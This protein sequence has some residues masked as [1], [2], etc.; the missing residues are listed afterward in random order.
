ME[1]GGNNDASAE[2]WK[3]KGNDLYKKADYRGAIDM[4]TMAIELS[5][6]TAAYYANRA[7]G[8]LMLNKFQEAIG[9]SSR[10][11]AMEPTFLRGYQRKAKAQ[12]A[13]GE[14]EAAIK[15]YQ[16]GLLKD[17]N[18]AT[19]INDRRSAEIAMDK[20]NRGRDHVK[21][22][23]FREAVFCF[24]SALTICTHSNDLKKWRAEALIG[25]ERYDE[26]FAVL[27]QL[28]RSD[29]SS[30]EIFYLRAQ[31]LYYQG[32]FTSAIRHL[33]EA[34]RADPD[35]MR[36]VK[37]I[38][39]IRALDT[40]K[41]AANDAFKSGRY[42]D[43]VDAYTECLSIDPNNKSYNAKLHCNRAA[44]L[45]KLNKNEEAIKD[46]DKAI[47]YDS[48][49]VKAYLRKAQCLKDLGGKE[50]LEQAL[51]E[52]ETASKLV[53]EDQQRQYA[54][55]IRETKLQLKKAKRKDYY[56]ILDIAQS[57]SE[58]DIKKAYRKSA[59]KYHPDRHANKT[60]EEKKQAEIDFK[61]VGEAYAV[62]SD[63]QKKQRYDSGVDLEDLDNDMGGMGGGMGGMN[64]NDIFQMFFNQ[65]GGGGMGGMGGFGGG[66][67]GGGGGGG[68]GRGGHSHGGSGTSFRF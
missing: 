22:G 51:R 44:A 58:A 9:D 31:C 1:F 49:Y 15:T 33:Q 66:G 21:A 55:Y 34:L 32:E 50:H 27:T 53:G 40:Q 43:A 2:E 4:Y 28:M 18:D 39:R 36:F 29:S 23:K 12:V 63:A 25:C 17:P 14:L 48:S 10:A 13:L 67:F 64:P 46:C 7:A 26:A 54:Q 16:A 45:A 68:F 37:E 42:Q 6:T 20:I 41:E 65:Q 60:E 52:Y 19:L 24:D 47:Y 8:Y 35:N 5:P 61:D 59:L 62:L 30:P 38:K 11:I 3:T 57:A 56:K